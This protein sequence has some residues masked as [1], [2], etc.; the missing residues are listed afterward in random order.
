VF[1][2][3]CKNCGAFLD[4]AEKCDCETLKRRKIRAVQ[5]LLSESEEGQIV[6]DFS[7]LKKRKRQNYIEEEL[8]NV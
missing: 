3:C 4:P 7:S 1:N 6:I 8:L 2:Y 5:E